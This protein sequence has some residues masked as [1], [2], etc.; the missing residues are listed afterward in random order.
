MLKL[1]GGG[2]WDGRVRNVM[3][4]LPRKEPSLV[5]IIKPNH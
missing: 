2:F 3:D 1:R 5:K 4:P